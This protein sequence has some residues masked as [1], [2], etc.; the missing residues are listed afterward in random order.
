MP[1]WIKYIRYNEDNRLSKE[2]Y[3]IFY[4]AIHKLNMMTLETFESFNDVSEDRFLEFG[5]YFMELRSPYVKEKVD[6]A[7]LREFMG[8][9]V[10]VV[11]STS[12]RIDIAKQLVNRP[13]CACVLIFSM[14][15]HENSTRF[16]VHIY[17]TAEKIKTIGINMGDIAKRFHG[18]GQ[19]L[20]GVFNLYSN[21][22]EYLKKPRKDIIYSV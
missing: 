1:W 13:E 11:K 8:L 6:G 9:N 15:A 17:T 16:K 19:I 3:N 4:Y 21:I 10:Y 12:M 5:K 22:Y 20:S 18:S 14:S 2:E 7:R